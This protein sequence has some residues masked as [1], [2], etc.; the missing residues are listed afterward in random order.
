VIGALGS[1]VIVSDAPQLLINHWN[2]RAK[3]LVIALH[4]ALEEFGDLIGGIFGHA[5][6]GTALL[7]IQQHI[8]AAG[9]GQ[10]G[11]VLMSLG[12]KERAF[13]FSDEAFWPAF[14]H[15]PTA[16][17]NSAT[18]GGREHDFGCPADS[19]SGPSKNRDN[20]EHAPCRF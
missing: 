13:S 4:P 2:Q 5:A 7:L 8:L 19:V 14:A 11:P 15:I 20:Q 12:A 9:G 18:D 6:D 16:T 1:Q 10:I 17:R 3:G